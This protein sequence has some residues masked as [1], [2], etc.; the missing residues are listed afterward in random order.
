MSAPPPS[1]PGQ[2]F[3]ELREARGIP[4]ARQAAKLVGISHTRIREIEDAPGRI[5]MRTST[6]QAFARA[7]SVHVNLIHQIA[8]GVLENLPS[9][10]D[11]STDHVGGESDRHTGYRRDRPRGRVNPVR[12]LGTVS[13]GLNAD[14]V[15]QP[16]EYLAV[17]DFFTNGHDPDE[18]FALEVTGDSMVSE[19]KRQE[20]P[21]G[22]IVLISENLAPRDGM[23][24][25]AWLENED[26]AVLK[27]FHH[28]DDTETTWL[29]S[30]N[31]DHKP[32]L[33]DEST[34]AVIRGVMVGQ[35][36][37]GPALQ[38]GD[39]GGPRDGHLRPHF[40][41]HVG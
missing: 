23:V 15:M 30:H 7:Y 12:F 32:I 16:I 9:D 37:R 11:A 1:L 28:G 34:P 38:P 33:I 35:W 22:S 18:L 24:V 13:A 3:Q 41:R 40:R 31:P 27:T 25:V 26:I 17:S 39:R 5:G 19:D 36:K 21:P 6:A 20:I 10:L 8:S 4:S 2:I 29:L 14:G